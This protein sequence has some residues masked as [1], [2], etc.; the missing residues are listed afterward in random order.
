MH[1]YANSARF[2][3]IARPLTGW[4]FSA[5]ALLTASALGAGLFLAPHDY[6]QGDSVRIVNV[7]VPAA[8]PAMAGRASWPA[9]ATRPRP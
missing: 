3:K 6:L 1:G 7:H 8:W 9:S 5:G 4:L 2:L